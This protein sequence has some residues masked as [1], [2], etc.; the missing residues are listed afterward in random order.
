MILRRR[1][2]YDIRPIKQRTIS[3]PSSSV[4]SV[5]VCNAYPAL[6]N[7]MLLL[8]HLW[9][10]L[11][12]TQILKEVSP[13]AR[14][15][16]K[17]SR[18]PQWHAGTQRMLG[19]WR[20]ACQCSS[21]YERTLVNAHLNMKG[22]PEL[23]RWRNVTM[24]HWRDGRERLHFHRMLSDDGLSTRNMQ[25]YSINGID[26]LLTDLLEAAQRKTSKG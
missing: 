5:T 12:N 15:L 9:E 4:I 17:S 10:I 26:K 7:G 25:L 2:I 19:N 24:N 1:L 14:W 6:V 13:V 8:S 3:S 22:A 20:Y 16:P 23:E 11:I 18:L 21:Q